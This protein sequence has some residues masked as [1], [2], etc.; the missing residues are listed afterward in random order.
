MLLSRRARDRQVAA[1]RRRCASGSAAEP[2]RRLRYTARPTTR[3][4]ALCPVI[5]QLERAAGF[6]RDDAPEVKLDKLEALLGRAV[7]DAARGS[8]RSWRRLLAHRRL[9][10]LPGRSISRRSS[11]RQRTFEAL[12]DQLEGLPRRGPV[13]IVVEDVHWLDPTTLELFDLIVDRLRAPAGAAG[14]HLPPRVPA[15]LDR[16]RRT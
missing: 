15:A 2:P 16:P 6:A 1:R 7:A 5:E 10:A 9:G 4:S 13:L 11:A 14:R 3:N 12:L 8:A